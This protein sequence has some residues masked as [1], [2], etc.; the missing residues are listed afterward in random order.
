M[1][2]HTQCCRHTVSLTSAVYLCVAAGLRCYTCTAADPRSCTDSKSC[3]VVFNRCFSMKIDG[4]LC[5]LCVG[6]VDCCEGDLC[7]SASHAGSSFILLMVS[8]AMITLFF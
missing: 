5:M 1:E 3:P 6:A 7:N 2:T 8:S 4:K